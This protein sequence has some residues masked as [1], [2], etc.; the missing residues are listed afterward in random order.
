MSRSRIPWAL[1]VVVALAL[2]V[3]QEPSTAASNWTLSVHGTSSGESRSKSLPSAPGSATAS[4][5]SVIS[6]T[7]KVT[8]SAVT[9]A[10]S[11]TVYEATSAASGPYSSAATGVTS[12]S[13]TSPGLSTGDYWF[14]VAA[15]EGANWA[16]A[17]SSATAESTVTGPPITA[18]LQP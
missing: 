2:S 11:Y 10:S 12:T 16:S 7:I 5:T 8:W 1:A 3:T 9:G 6:N 13:W 4:C 17:N 14:E 18:C 15:Y